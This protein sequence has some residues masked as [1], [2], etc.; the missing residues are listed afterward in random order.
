[1]LIRHG[2]DPRIRNNAGLTARE[3]YQQ[4][5]EGFLQ[6]PYVTKLLQAKEDEYVKAQFK[7]DIE[8]IQKHGND[9]SMDAVG[10]VKKKQIVLK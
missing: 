8:Q 6:D 4:S 3:Q 1:V 5:V 10:S 9:G 2:A 7:E